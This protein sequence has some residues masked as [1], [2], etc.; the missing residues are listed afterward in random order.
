MEVIYDKV[1]R[2]L[3]NVERLL[4]IVNEKPKMVEELE[5]NI[6]SLRTELFLKVAECE[7]HVEEAK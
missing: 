2:R 5:S 4:G 3:I 7:N 1:T 6:N